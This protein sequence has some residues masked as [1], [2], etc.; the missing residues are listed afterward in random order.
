MLM[1]PMDFFCEFRYKL[2]AEPDPFFPRV[3][4]IDGNNVRFTKKW[5]VLTTM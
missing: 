2:G 3:C 5:T 1:V 4:S